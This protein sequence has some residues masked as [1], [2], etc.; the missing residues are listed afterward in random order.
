MAG[1]QSGRAPA[2]RAAPRCERTDQLHQRRRIQLSNLSDRTSLEGFSRNEAIKAPSN[3]LRGPIKEELLE[4]TPA[5]A[6][7][8]EQLIKFHGI[9]QQ[10]ARD[11]RKEA[12]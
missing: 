11:R 4:D 5:F 2:L 6:E 3:H 7:V 12:R 9:C 1:H 10:D 8:S